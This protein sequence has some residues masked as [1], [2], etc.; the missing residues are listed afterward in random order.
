MVDVSLIVVGLWL[1]Y[2]FSALRCLTGN[3]V[4][5]FAQCCLNGLLLIWIGDLPMTRKNNND[6]HL[7]A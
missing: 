1:H 2:L 6:N 3:R 5:G 7:R 4:E